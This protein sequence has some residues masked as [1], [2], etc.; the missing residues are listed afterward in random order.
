VVPG[1]GQGGYQQNGGAGM[2]EAGP[3]LQVQHLAKTYAIGFMRRKVKAITDV[4]LRVESGQIFGLLGPNGS[5]KTTT[6]KVLMGL[7]RRTAGEA[8]LLGA[9]VGDLAAKRQLGYLPESPYFYDYLTGREL[10]VFMGKL[11]GLNGRA[12]ASRADQLLAEVGLAESG[13][14]ALRRYSKGMLQRVGLA[15][16]LVN[17]PALVIL[18]EPMSGLDPLGRKEVRELIA[19]LRRSGKTVLFSS[20][21]LSDVE[22]LADRVAILV[23]GRTVDTGPLDKL[24]DARVLSTEIV[25]TGVSGELIGELRQ[26][27]SEISEAGKSVQLLTTGN[28]EEVNAILDLAR[29]RG[30]R[31]QMV[32]PRK[33]S[34]EDVVVKQAKVSD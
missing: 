10:L 33:E 29:R 32:L 2:S 16:A 1:E 24:L 15:Q 28:E 4:N 19:G 17:D 21:I 31:V 6:L 34:L 27:A 14:L 18:D 26:H 22:L 5:G 11:F 23:R 13:D 20:H 9:P 30:A 7:I 3:A 8:E 25:L 12:A